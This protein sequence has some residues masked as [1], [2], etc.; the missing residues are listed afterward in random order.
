MNMSLEIKR[1]FAAAAIAGFFVATP[2]AHAATV[3]AMTQPAS[4]LGERSAVLNGSVVTSDRQVST[5]F[6]EW[7][8]DPASI[9]NTT[10]MQ[11]VLSGASFYVPIGGLL[12]DTTYYY[13][14]V[15][16]HKT[17]AEVSRGTTLSF[18]TGTK[19]VAP[20]K[21]PAAET[22]SA[23]G[24]ADTYATLRGFADPKGT[25]DTE[26]WF[27]WGTTQSLGN[28]TPRARHGSA[29]G[30]FSHALSGLSPGTT[31]YYRALAQNAAGNS[32]GTIMSL[33]TTGSVATPT[34][35]PAPGGTAPIAITQPAS[36]VTASE[37][38]L[39]GLA[40]PGGT[41]PS[42]A[43]FEWGSTASLGSVTPPNALIDGASVPFSAR[44]SNLAPST[45]YSY[46]AV[47]ETPRGTVVGAILQFTTRSTA[48]PSGSPTP[49]SSTSGTS[50]GTA[51]TSVATSTNGGTAAASS[52]SIF[53]DSLAGWL[54]LVLL[55]LLFLA[56]LK[57]LMG[58]YQDIKRKKEMENEFLE[59]KKEN[60]QNGTVIR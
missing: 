52:F 11:D 14:A 49:G 25:N 50:N 3:S 59:E 33:R 22:K 57:F 5:V 19:A 44:L 21:L 39:A 8:T 13:R 30:D 18:S 24:I 56:F 10:N 58:K 40:L 35:A 48:S 2:L 32:L 1:L 6:F 38:T 47:V 4:S 29:P 20:A 45:T 37:A 36:G 27:E 15:A 28:Q 46:R 60:L 23:E 51:A 54:I 17:S 26:R 7:G 41:G 55:I 42:R 16:I 12:S 9:T 53:P 34:P 31:Y 43:W